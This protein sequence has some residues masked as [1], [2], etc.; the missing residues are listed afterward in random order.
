M[1]RRSRTRLSS[2]AV[3]GTFVQVDSS[4]SQDDIDLLP[5][6]RTSAESEVG[7]GSCSKETPHTDRRTFTISIPKMQK[8]QPQWLG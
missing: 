8:A 5:L 7:D 6:G 2:F 3:R 1:L 4:F